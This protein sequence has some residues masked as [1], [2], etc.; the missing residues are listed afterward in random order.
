MLN[1]Y[2][3]SGVMHPFTCPLCGADLV[4]RV[5]GW[6][7]PNDWYT[8]TWAHAFMANGEW[9]SSTKARLGRLGL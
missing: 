3:R 1:D 6:S 4:A 5:R 2:Q 8:Q 9:L 7:C